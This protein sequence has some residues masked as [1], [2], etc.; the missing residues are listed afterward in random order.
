MISYKK[1]CKCNSKK[2]KTLLPCN[3]VYNTHH[4]CL[5]CLLIDFVKCLNNKTILLCSECNLNYSDEIIKF[6]S[7]LPETFNYYEQNKF[8]RLF[9]EYINYE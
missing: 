4:K 3:N 1:I 9:E 7:V 5:D 2:I 6:I 8:D